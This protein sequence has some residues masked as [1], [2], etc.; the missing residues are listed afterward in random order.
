[1]QY[2]AIDTESKGGGNF[3]KLIELYCI[4]WSHEEG[5]GI[6]EVHWRP[7]DGPLPQKY[8]DEFAD[9]VGLRIPVFHGASHDVPLLRAAGLDIPYYLDTLT[10][11]CSVNPNISPVSAPG[12]KPS[13]YGL[14][15][16]GIRLGFPKLERPDFTQD[17]DEGWIPYAIRDAELTF[18]LFEYLRAIID[19]DPAAWQHY[20]TVVRPYIE[21]II[22]MNDVGLYVDKEDLQFYRTILHNKMLE[23]AANIN[24]MVPLVPGKKFYYADEYE[25]EEVEGGL[26]YIGKETVKVSRKRKGQVIQEEVERHAYFEWAKF[27]PNSNDHVAYVL[28]ANGWMPEEYTATGKPKLDKNVL[29]EIDDPIVE[30]VLEHRLLTKLAGT[31]ADKFD[32]EADQWGYI[33]CSWNQTG[34]I[35]GRLSS[36]S[37][38]LQNVPARKVIGQYMRKVFHNPSDDWLVWDVDL[39]NIEYRV[40]A[41]LQYQ[42]YLEHYGSVPDDVQLMVN[43]FNDPNGDIHQEM[44]NLWGVERDDSKTLSF[45]RIYGFKE[46]RAAMM[47][48]CSVERAKELIEQANATNPSFEQYHKHVVAEY[49]D[50]NGIAHT[51]FGRRLVYPM[52][53]L[54]DR[55]VDQTV[56]G[57]FKVPAAKVRSERSRA[58]RQ[59]FNAKIQGTSADILQILSLELLEPLWAIGGRMAASVHDELF[60]YIPRNRADDLLNLVHS[61]FNRP[62]G[63]LLPGVAVM[64]DPQVGTSW[65]DCKASAIKRQKLEEEFI[66]LQQNYGAH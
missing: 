45:G 23:V 20:D 52:I 58:I 24:S 55:R 21:I 5:S 7:E 66:K 61:V 18:K 25:E 29:A 60:G 42:Y 34:T 39:S 37:P 44:A 48:H 43:T 11:G 54:E 16:W 14:E 41:A 6:L 46:H 57:K 65:F 15:A 19:K 1:M 35:T 32:R 22:E 59:G 50:G 26:K 13:K 4:T 17:W 62:P 63:E 64:G 27:N 40:L 36:S 10:L 38:N 47:L 51:L 12:I 8:R 56:W 53:T 9:I 49:L 28:Q 2:I 3:G 30:H 31:Y 33:H